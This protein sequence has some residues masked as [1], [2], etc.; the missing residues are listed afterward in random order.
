MGLPPSEVMAM[1]LHDYQA[2]L[3]FWNKAHSSEDDDEPLTADE[4]DD[5]LAGMNSAG[6]H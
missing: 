4:F 6:V 2:A 5:M 3:H 1:P